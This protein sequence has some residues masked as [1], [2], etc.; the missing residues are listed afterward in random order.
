MQIVICDD[1]PKEIESIQKLLLQYDP[2]QQFTCHCFSSTTDLLHAAQLE[3]FDLILMDI[4]MANI[5]GFDAAQKLI[6]QSQPPL[7]IFITKS[8]AY[9][10]RGYGIALRYLVKPVVW[11][12][13]RDA[14]DAALL[15]YNANRLSFHLG[16]CNFALPIP[17]I[18]YIESYNHTTIVHTLKQDYTIRIPLSKLTSKLPRS[19]FVSPQKSYLVNMHYI[20]SSTPKE[21]RLEN[22]DIIPISRRK[23]M[24]FD[25][26]FNEFLGR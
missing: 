7:I 20:T 12:E 25:A 15:E 24:D 1:E 6:L 23:R 19:C 22:G 3:N 21:I 10:V 2:A 14:L 4:E 9:S 11:D 16:E 8:S 13:F 18:L 26:C 17:S 5:S